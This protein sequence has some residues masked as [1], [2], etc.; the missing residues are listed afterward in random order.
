[1]IE[2]KDQ[3]KPDE[4]W[5]DREVMITKY[6]DPCVVVRSTKR[7]IGWCGILAGSIGK[8]EKKVPGGLRIFFKSKTGEMW[9]DMCVPYSRLD[10]VDRG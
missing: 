8:V 3:R 4:W 5:Y 9:I 6:I 10:L 7:H 1:M 2:R